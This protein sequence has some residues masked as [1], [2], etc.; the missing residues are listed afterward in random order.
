MWRVLWLAPAVGILRWRFDFV[1]KIHAST[2]HY[3]LRFFYH[4]GRTLLKLSGFAHAHIFF[5]RYVSV[6]SFVGTIN[7]QFDYVL[8]LWNHTIPSS[9]V[10]NIT[11]YTF[12]ARAVSTKI[13]FTEFSRT[14]AVL[15]AVRTVV[16]VTSK[17]VSH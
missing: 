15:I 13:G 9:T 2:T 10:N 8:R 12:G 5:A 11:N 7:L 16:I 17:S 6:V 1:L 3:F 4:E 14:I